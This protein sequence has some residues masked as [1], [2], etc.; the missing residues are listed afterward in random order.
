MRLRYLNCLGQVGHKVRLR[1][2]NCL[3][4]V[5]HMAKDELKKWIVNAWVSK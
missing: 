1:Y 2:L 5:G 4:Q 3:G